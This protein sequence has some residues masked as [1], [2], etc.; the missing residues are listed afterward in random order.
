MHQIN[1]IRTL[2]IETSK[3]P[4]GLFPPILNAVFVERNCDY[5]L[6]GNNFLNRQR[7]NLVRYDT[8]YV[9]LLAPKI[10]GVL[11]MGYS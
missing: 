2:A 3:V 1:I 10:W 8:E 7:V 6:R 9:S 5:R 4:H 11:S